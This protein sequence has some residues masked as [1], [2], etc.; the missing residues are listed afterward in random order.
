MNPNVSKKLGTRHRAALGL[1]E[2]SDAVIL[3]VSEETGAISLAYNAN[4]YYNLDLDKTKNMLI[5]LL[6]GKE[7]VPQDLQKNDNGKEEDNAE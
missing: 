3:I 1:S 6:S 7:V 4:I 5:M 2:E